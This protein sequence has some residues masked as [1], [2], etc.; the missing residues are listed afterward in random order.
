[1]LFAGAVP[2]TA[3]VRGTSNFAV[4]FAGKGPR[5]SRGRSLRDLDLT[6]RLLRYPLSYM[7]Y[8]RSFDEMPK[9][10]RAYIY[11]RLRQVLT[12]EDKSS[13]FAYL[14][15]TDRKAI[16]EILRETKPEFART[17]D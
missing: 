17:T 10:V 6:T 12:G 5:D 14:S 3:P 2:L 13:D 4:E 9:E 15:G 8:S 7:I 1:M 11:R 16:Q